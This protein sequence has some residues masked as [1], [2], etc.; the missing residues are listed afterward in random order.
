MTGAHAVTAE[1]CR[2]FWQGVAA[3][4]TASCLLTT[5]LDGLEGPPLLPEAGPVDGGSRDGAAGAGSDASMDDAAYG[6]GT[7]KGPFLVSAVSGVPRGITVRGPDLYWV[8]TETN[9]GIVHAE[10]HG[11]APSFFHVTPNAFDVAVD[12]D[13]VY[14]SSGQ[15]NEVFRKT[16]ASGGAAELLF[17]GAGETLYMAAGDAGRLFVTGSNGVVIG[18]RPDAG[19]SDAL[20]L[21]QLGAAGIALKGTELYFGVT[22]GLV[23]GGENGQAAPEAVYRTA[24]GEIGGVATDE[25]EIY[26]ITVDGVV[27]ALSLEPSATTPREVCRASAQPFD[28]GLP[29]DGGA[30]LGLADVAVDE[31]WVYFTEP[32]RR[33]VSKCFK[34]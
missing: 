10:K 3:I 21:S 7:S 12:D 11:Q 8:Q 29:A 20:Y 14:W 6:D 32:A 5:P 18:P 26:W 24:P 4:S 34:R 13:Y 19:T 30:S 17:A 22:A 27:R 23:R 9:S 25:A 1:R 28:A 33:R 31:Q 15:G 2:P 16:I